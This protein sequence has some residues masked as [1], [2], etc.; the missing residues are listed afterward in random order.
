MRLR[1]LR[2]C[3]GSVATV[4]YYWLYWTLKD[5]SHQTS[6]VDTSFLAVI[7]WLT[8]IVYLIIAHIQYPG[9]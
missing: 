8:S 2:F 1:W 9:E 3:L 7:G 4:F 5:A 6:A